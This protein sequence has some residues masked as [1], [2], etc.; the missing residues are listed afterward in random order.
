VPKGGEHHRPQP[1]TQN[2]LTEGEE[3]FTVLGETEREKSLAGGRHGKKRVKINH[4]QR[5]FAEG[6]SSPEKK[7]T[8]HKDNLNLRDLHE[9][10]ES[11]A[12]KKVD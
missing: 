5:P 10:K 3:G 4:E 9:Q 7:N 8:P 2:P 11:F 6:K 1:K 12:R